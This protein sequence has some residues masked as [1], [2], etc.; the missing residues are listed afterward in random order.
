[1]VSDICRARTASDP[2]LYLYADRCVLNDA[3]RRLLGADT[4]EGFLR[5]VNNLDARS[6]M[7]R[8]CVFVG[9]DTSG[10]KYTRYRKSLVVNS[11]RLCSLLSLRLEGYGTYRVCPDSSIED[12][13]KVFYEIFFR[14]YKD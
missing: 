10:Y 7:E 13:D 14:K 9:Q 11:R 8:R 2:L 5:F 1:M 4:P 6:E 12:A 3:A